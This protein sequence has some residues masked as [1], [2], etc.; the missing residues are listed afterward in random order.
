MAGVLHFR[1]NERLAAENYGFNQSILLPN[2]S[3]VQ[4]VSLGF[5]HLISDYY[6]LAFVNY[7]GDLEKRKVDRFSRSAEYLTLVTELDPSFI[8]AYWFSSFII[9]GDKGDPEEAS[10]ILEHGIR[11]NP[12][13]WQLPF[14]AGINRYLNAGDEK[15]AAR[16]YRMASKYASAPSWLAKQADI[17]ETG[18]PRLIKEA[19]SWLNIYN[20]SEEKQVKQYAKE[21]SIRLW[22][23]VYKNAPNDVY[24][25]KAKVALASLD[26]D[27]NLF[28][29]LKR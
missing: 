29:K 1:L 10:A 16:Y 3:T 4:T 23:Q 19:H 6:W 24:R 28:A 15:G 9:G 14:I 5:D 11:A 21:Q 18:S 25:Q 7:I 22:V 20:S 13:N 2:P 27:V 8:Q 17:I 26:V 12:D